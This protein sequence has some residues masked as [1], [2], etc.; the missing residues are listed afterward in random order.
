MPNRTLREGIRSSGFINRLSDQGFRLYVNLLATADDF[1][2]IEWTA[3]WIKAE[4]IPLLMWGEEQVAAAM[5]EL[6]E[7]RVVRLYEASGRAYAAVEK[8]DQRRNAKHPKF[9]V[10]PWGFGPGGESHITGGYVAP[11]AMRGE[12]P[13]GAP[14]RRVP[15]KRVNG[16]GWANTNDG[17]LAK[18][19]ELGISTRGESTDNL[20]RLCFAEI[21]RRTRAQTT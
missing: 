7:R 15:P 21:D 1:G 6:A 8:W 11:S 19:T 9:P 18:A 12:Q 14:P 2:C 17:I 4:A 13:A 16:S 5:A 20:K 3:T 10:P